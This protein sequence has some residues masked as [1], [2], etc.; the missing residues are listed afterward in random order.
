[1]ALRFVWLYVSS[2]WQT[3][4]AR[5]ER[6]PLRPTWSLSFEAT[7]RALRRDWDATAAW[8]LARLR[9]EVNT[10]PYPLGMARKVRMEDASLGGVPVVVF[11]P[12]DGASPGAGTVL[13]FHGGS[14]IYG[15]SRTT[16]ADT[17]ARLAVACRTRVVSVEYRLAPEHP[18]PAQR[19]DALAVFRALVAQGTPPGRIIVCGDSA[20]GNL[21]IELQ[22]ALRDLGEP[23]A[24]AAVLLS[25]WCDLTM[26]G[27]SFRDNDPFDFG[28]REV[29]VRH[30]RA[31][32]G[33]AALD[34]PRV[35]PAFAR[36][37]GL[38]PTFVAAGEAEIPRDDILAFAERLRSAGV[39][40]TLEVSRDMPHNAAVF[41]DMHP[42]GEALVAA[43]ARFVGERF[44]P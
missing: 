44:A 28:T 43:V 25:P 2:F 17:I 11:E 23:Q 3:V 9:E 31:F 40:V 32:S 27:A 18:F 4:A 36:L 24:G 14:Y 16:H 30:A 21:A 42:S 38:A 41:A 39:D 6:G 7:L 15:S 8:P 10:R 1:M 37:E 12:R 34:D 20:G 13:F 19:D 35:S 29:L 22:L 26:P 33:D 5:V